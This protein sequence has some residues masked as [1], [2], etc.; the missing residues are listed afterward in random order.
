[1][2]QDASA[3]RGGRHGTASKSWQRGDQDELR[4]ILD[5]Y[6]L[7][8][9]VVQRC[10]RFPRHHRY[11]LGIAV[12]NRLQ[13]ILGLLIAAKYAARPAKAGLLSTT[14]TELQVLRF[15]LRL[16][17]DLR[18]L[19][20]KSHGHAAGLIDGVGVQ[21]GG[22]L[23]SMGGGDETGERAVGSG[24]HVGEPGAGGTESPSRQA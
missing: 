23:R 12:E 20:L 10:E 2:A 14:N 15:Q 19:S 5:F 3:S 17:R 8:L 16:A 24:G 6:D 1:M 7:M 4:V 11:S 22:W 13:T 9:Y 21:V 18:A